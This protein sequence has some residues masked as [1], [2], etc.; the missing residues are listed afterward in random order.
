MLKKYY[1]A[2][3]V[4]IFLL[5]SA[6]SW[7]DSAASAERPKKDANP[8][9]QIEQACKSAGFVY[10]NA[11]DGKGLMRDC[12]N[13]IMQSKTVAGG[14][15]LPNIDPGVVSA[16]KAKNPKFGEGETGYTPP[17]KGK[18]DTPANTVPGH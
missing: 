3:G 4:V 1:A 6:I 14:A 12:V 15:Q 7:A 5:S 9:H 18:K 16:C 17:S 2:L 10:G 11:K 13:P 8:C